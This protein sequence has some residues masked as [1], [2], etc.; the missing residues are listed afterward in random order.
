[1]KLYV[2]EIGDK[3]KLSE[4]WKF[5]LHAEYRNT[6]LAL[7]FGYYYVNDGW[8]DSK[9][10]PEIRN[11]DYNVIYPDRSLSLSYFEYNDACTRAEENCPEYVQY[12]KEYNEW[13]HKCRKISA[14]TIN[15]TIPAGTIIKVD[16]I[17][18]RKGS[19]DYSSITFYAVGLGEV[20]TSSRWSVSKPKKQKSLRFWCKL[21]DCNNIVF[22]KEL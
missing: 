8:V 2:P 14:P 17:Y 4:D 19:S 18:I 16:R 15:I 1:M 11:R 6:T 20:I 7:L 10:I 12:H 3:L 9:I 22:E 13:L 5:D 21:A